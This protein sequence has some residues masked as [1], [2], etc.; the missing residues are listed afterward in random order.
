VKAKAVIVLALTLAA[1]AFAGPAAAYA[2]SPRMET[3]SAV[4]WVSLYADGHYDTHSG[5]TGSMVRDPGW[6]ATEDTD[7]APDRPAATSVHDGFLCGGG[8][9]I[10]TCPSYGLGERW[11]GSADANAD[12]HGT[13]GVVTRAY[14]YVSGC[15]ANATVSGGSNVE[16]HATAVVNDT[17]T[18]NRAATVTV[19][20]HVSASLSDATGDAI[21]IGWPQHVDLYAELGFLRP[22]DEGSLRL[23]GW[24]NGYGIRHVDDDGHEVGNVPCETTFTGQCGG[25]LVSEDFETHIALP[26]GTSSFSAVLNAE[27]TVFGLADLRNGEG[28]PAGSGQDAAVNASD[29]LTFEIVV[30]DDVVATSGSGVLPIVGGQP[31]SDTTGPVVTA[32]ADVHTTNGDGTCATPVNPG[33]AT[34]ADDAPGVAIEGIRS[35]GRPLGDPYPVG[36]TTITW[37][38]T[39]AAGNTDSATQTVTVADGEPPTVDPPADVSTAN[40][41]GRADASVDPGTATA[42]DNCPGVTVEGVRS[43][44]KPLDAAYPVGTTTITWTAT[45]A[46]GATAAATQSVEVVDAE[47]PV[48]TLPADMTVDATDASGA[49]VPYTVG[50]TDNVGVVSQA[51]SPTAG[52]IFGIGDTTVQCTA[53][54]AAG[55]AATGQFVVHVRGAAEQ[56]DALT[57]SLPPGSLQAKA[58]AAVASTTAG[59]ITTACQQLDALVHE[60]DAQNGKQLTSAEADAI[61]DAV[62]RI[63]SVLGC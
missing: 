8:S 7:T 46:A 5:Q 43:D 32:P 59:R 31:A 63:R 6:V 15:N 1:L 19:R 13:L 11:S 10:C 2:P 29:S 14:V 3:T 12:L 60:V 35:D 41:P 30:P 17:V 47:P 34:A 53:S 50:V 42:S 61:R 23:D 24:G 18:L 22:G 48:L 55:N 27:T 37:T 56:L 16:T 25:G 9:A 51:C 44:G 21:A 52:S 57:G 33:T 38:A 20:G 40:D 4:A 26:E 28:D 49:A 39:D 54:D 45:D 62:G 58:H 36:T